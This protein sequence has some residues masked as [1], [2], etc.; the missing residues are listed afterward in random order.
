VADEAAACSKRSS[1]DTT[2][3]AHSAGNPSAPLG[4][5]GTLLVLRSLERPGSLPHD[6][7]RPLR[8]SPLADRAGQRRQEVL[9][10]RFPESVDSPHASQTAQPQLSF[11]PK[12][13]GR[14][15]TSKASWW[16]LGC[17]SLNPYSPAPGQSEPAATGRSRSS[18]S[19]RD[20]LEGVPLLV[21]SRHC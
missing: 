20:R 2:A 17:R 21:R 13:Y 3:D 19:L 10:A 9:A 8:P 5:L 18:G 6:V 1:S 12:C 16:H 7:G 14:T 4:A 15:S 11:P